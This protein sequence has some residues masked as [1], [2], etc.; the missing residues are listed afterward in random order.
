MNVVN[1]GKKM[2]E[3]NVIEWWIVGTCVLWVPNESI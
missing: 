1:V 2:N 3:N